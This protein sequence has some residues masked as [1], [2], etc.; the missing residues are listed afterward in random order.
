[1]LIDELDTKRGALNSAIDE[2]L[3]ALTGTDH[4][5][6]ILKLHAANSALHD[7][8]HLL[9]RAERARRAAA[10][11]AIGVAIAARQSSRR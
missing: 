1:M 2:A 8:E 6:I 4:S 9:D 5:A 3:A 10:N 11:D 7:L